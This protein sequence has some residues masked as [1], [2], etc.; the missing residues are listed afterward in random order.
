MNSF[1]AISDHIIAFL[2]GMV[3]PVFSGFRAARGFK[4]LR[5]DEAQRRRFYFFNS[6][7]LWTVTIIV[8]LNWWLHGRCA[9][10]LGITKSPQFPAIVIILSGGF[11]VLYILEIAISAGNE[12]GMK[13]KHWTE[14]APFLPDS[15][16]QLPAYIFM[17]VTAGICEEI[18]FRGFLITYT[19]T[20]FETDLPAILIPA[21]VF[22]VAHYY[23]RT[24]AVIKIFLL[25]V[26][27]GFIFLRSGSLWIVMF[28]HFAIDLAGGLII[29]KY[30]YKEEKVINSASPAEPP[31]ATANDNTTNEET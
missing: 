15:Y 10:D 5:F 26:I 4:T 22:A 1:P 27:F 24:S 18:I 31:D 19:K 11:I 16:R 9:A 25:S 28:L 13:K 2:F 29:M 23:Q 17:C 30:H 7:F 8:L 20:F 12:T 6:L 3:L 21:A 14:V